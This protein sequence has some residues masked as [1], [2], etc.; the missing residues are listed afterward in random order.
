MRL[1]TWNVNSLNAR[2]DRVTEW[3]VATGTDVLC[4]QETK[5]ADDAFPA[6]AFGEIG[7]A[8]AHHGNGRWNGVAIVSRVGLDDPRPGFTGEL[9]AEVEQCRILAARCGGVDVVSV[10]VPNGRSVGSEHYEAKLVWLERLRVDLA[11]LCAAGGDVAVCG[12]FNIAPD[13][14]DVF[15]PAAFVGATHVTPEERAGLGRLLACGLVDV[16][17]Q[18]HPDGPGPFTW[19][20]YR[21][22]AFHKGEG[23]RIDLALC[24]TSLAARVRRVEVDRE[25]RKRSTGA[26]APSDHAPLVVD[27][28]DATG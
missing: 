16:A 2:L 24:S 20:D 25:A 21:A 19:W 10:Y 13:D 26:G 23:M 18:V 5:L 22:G 12:D 28:D 1:A 9:A 14:R 8:T 3:L 15:D 7:Y 27:L 11:S 4:L 6:E 17:R